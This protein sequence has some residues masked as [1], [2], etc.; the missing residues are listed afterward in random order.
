MRVVS[1]DPGIRNLGYVLME[2]IDGALKIELWGCV[3]FLT[4]G[5]CAAKNC[6][7]V[8]TDRTLLLLR[9]HLD[10]RFEGRAPV[11]AVV[12]E[13]QK[14]IKESAVASHVLGYF[15]ARGAAPRVMAPLAK[16]AD[17]LPDVRQRLRGNKADRHKQ[18]KLLAIDLVKEI[19]A[20]GGEDIK[21]F[22]KGVAPK[23]QEHISD[24]LLQGLVAA[25]PP[26]QAKKQ[27]EAPTCA[28]RENKKRKRCVASLL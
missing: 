5:G 17:R 20:A 18:L 24:A 10:A 7:A 22:W 19:V 26:K 3:D 28:S 13:A 16:F 27:Q 11:D 9:Q 21:A 14:G 25:K 6:R 23:Q 1:V 4:L 2:V 15:G 12:V 8:S